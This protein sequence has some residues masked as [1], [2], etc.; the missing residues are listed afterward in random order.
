MAQVRHLYMIF[1]SYG[2]LHL[3]EE[4]FGIAPTRSS[5]RSYQDLALG[6]ASEVLAASVYLQAPRTGTPYHYIR[7]N[8]ASFTHVM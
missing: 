8:E 2:L 4:S 1:L 6:Y 3:L 7:G 5:L